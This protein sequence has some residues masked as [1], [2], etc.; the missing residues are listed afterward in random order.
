MTAG[1]ITT[2]IAALITTFDLSFRAGSDPV[3]PLL[4]AGA[5]PLAVLLAG[6]RSSIVR[7]VAPNRSWIVHAMLITVFT[8]MP[9]GIPFG[10]RVGGFFVF[11]YE[12][13]A[14]GSFLYAIG[15][16]RASPAATTRLQNSVGVWATV[17][18][19]INVATGVISGLLHGHL[20][21]DIQIDVRGIADMMVVLFVVAVIFAVD[22]WQRY[23]KTII[24]ILTFSVVI[25]LYASVSGK[26]VGFR[27]EHSQLYDKTTSSAARFITQTTALALVI[28]LACVT[29]L[30]LGRVT[31]KHAAPM[32][33]PSLVICFLSFSRNTILAILGALAFAL[34]FALTHGNLGRAG[35][36]VAM[37]GLVTG[38]AI[39]GLPVLGQAIG[40]GHWVDEQVGGYVDRVVA[41]FEDSNVKRDASAQGRLSEDAHLLKSGAAHPAFGAGFGFR[42]KPPEGGG[43]RDPGDFAGTT[44]GQLYAHNT[45]L[46]FYVKVGIVGAATFLIVILVGVLPV[47]GRRRPSPVSVAAAGTLVG[48]GV[49]L[50]FVPYPLD[51]ANSAAVGL[52]IGASLEAGTLRAIRNPRL[53]HES[54]QPNVAIPSIAKSAQQLDSNF[55]AA[56]GRGG[57]RPQLEGFA[58]PERC[59]AKP[60]PIPR[61]SHTTISPEPTPVNSSELGPGGGGVEDVATLLG[62][63][64][65]AAV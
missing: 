34:V 8:T 49:A 45:Y 18:F 10:I 38:L 65:D 29:M 44:N 64:I 9:P 30:V 37:M 42:Y 21:K 58:V 32:L 2:T 56:A 43:I 12:F 46:W 54:Q 60:R 25:I 20:L 31:A 57:R 1:P 53:Q 28:V 19:G 47:L 24:T 16:L 5:F 36:R 3:L 14:F 7:R 13:F 11:F 48:L 35:P 63:R 61:L 51:Q 55:R 6:N 50:I 62:R 33:I 59:A 39:F 41:G 22:D 27:T 4:L 52:V 40:A 15:L 23:L 26:S 17:L